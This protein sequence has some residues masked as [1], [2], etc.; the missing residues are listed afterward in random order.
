MPDKAILIPAALLVVWT[1]VMA[2]WMLVDRAGTFSA[3]K[4]DPSKIEPGLRGS[5]LQKMLPPGRRDWPAHNYAHLMEQP[6]VYYAAVIM[7]SIGGPTGYDKVLAW[8]YLAL[9]VVHS[10]YQARINIVK[11]RAMIYVV[12]TLVMAILSVRALLSVL[13]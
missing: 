1:M 8:A 10:V 9:R 4:L 13:N 3:M 7:L 11:V 2:I 6:T 12:S 5:D